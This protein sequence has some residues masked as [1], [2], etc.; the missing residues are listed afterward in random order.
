MSLANHF[1]DILAAVPSALISSNILSTSAKSLASDFLNPIPY[2]SSVK[3]LFSTT[4]K[5]AFFSAI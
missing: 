4:T 5:G 3:G 1:S 2:N